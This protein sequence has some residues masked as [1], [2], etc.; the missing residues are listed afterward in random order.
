MFIVP[1][2][3]AL[4]NITV[5]VSEPLWHGSNLSVADFSI[6]NTIL[7]FKCS[8]SSTH[9]LHQEPHQLLISASRP[10]YWIT[11][12][13]TKGHSQLLFSLTGTCKWCQCICLIRDEQ[14]KRGWPSMHPS[15]I[16][17]ALWGGEGADEWNDLLG[18]SCGFSEIRGRLPLN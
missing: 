7:M 12:C 11:A 2:M 5:D 9:S 8:F 17:S 18:R 13:H 6:A 4:I 10:L 1:E 14:L 16:N 15:L 3:I